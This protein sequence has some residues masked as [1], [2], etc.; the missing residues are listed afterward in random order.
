MLSLKRKVNQVTTQQVKRQCTESSSNILS[1]RNQFTELNHV[2]RISI[3]PLLEKSGMDFR[4]GDTS[5]L[6]TFFNKYIPPILQPKTCVAGGYF[7]KYKATLTWPPFITHDCKIKH[8]TS[9][10]ELF[11]KLSD[12]DVFVYAGESDEDEAKT[13]QALSS[14][15]KCDNVTDGHDYYSCGPT[16]FNSFYFSVPEFDETVSVVVWR[17]QNEKRFANPLEIFCEMVNEFDIAWCKI[18]YAFTTKSIYMHNS[19][20]LGLAKIPT[21][22]SLMVTDFSENAQKSLQHQFERKLKYYYKGCFDTKIGYDSYFMH[23]IYNNEKF[24]IE[25]LVHLQKK[26]G[27]RRTKAGLPIGGV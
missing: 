26:F 5:K 4:C 22:S 14:T 6:E 24:L 23:Q 18:F 10:H 25:V 2:T 12:V 1:Q 16:K 21:D 19:I 8:H 7:M 9:I 3:D 27:S 20:L 13:F 11:K 15:L 17:F